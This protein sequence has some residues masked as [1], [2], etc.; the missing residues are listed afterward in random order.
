M[1]V[2]LSRDT[3]LYLSTV[4]VGFTEE[5][6]TK[7]RL[8]DGYKLTQGSQL[9]SYSTF[10][11]AASPSRVETKYVKDLD[12]V[13]LEFDTYCKTSIYGGLAESSDLLLWDSFTNHG[14]TQNASKMSIDFLTSSTNIFPSLFIYVVMGDDVFKLS[15]CYVESVTFPID[16]TDISKTKWS[17]KALSYEKVASV[18]NIYKDRTEVIGLLKSKL[19]IMEF[20]RQAQDYHLPLL[21]GSISIKNKVIMVS[22]P[23][24]SAQLATNRRIRIEDRSVEASIS[25]YLRTGKARSFGLLESMLTSLATINDLTNITIN[26]GALTGRRV[27]IQMPQAIISL[28]SINLSD[29]VSTDIQILPVETGIGQNDDITIEYYN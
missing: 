2:I 25:V 18:P 12:L 26:I 27:A 20:N 1:A 19:S 14:I 28:P 3:E 22:T 16:I 4:D 23:V 29:V 5:T 8:L 17:I 10:R 24:V 11:N 6:T 13:S 15:D 21:R 7:L 9:N